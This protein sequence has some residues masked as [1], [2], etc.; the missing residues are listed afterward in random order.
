M[1]IVCPNCATPYQVESSEIGGGRSVR[2]VRCKN[3]WLAQPPAEAPALG[4]PE[5]PAQAAQST[6]PSPA[7]AS[8]E[9]AGDEAVAAFRTEL[10]AE[11]AALK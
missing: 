5:R 8:A 3:V 4:M 9:P 6:A 10:G 1:L 7:N 2:C 11:A